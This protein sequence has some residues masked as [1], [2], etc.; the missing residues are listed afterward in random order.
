M[1]WIENMQFKEENYK[2][3][4]A[5]REKTTEQQNRDK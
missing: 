3:I 1:L 2:R 5:K 4:I